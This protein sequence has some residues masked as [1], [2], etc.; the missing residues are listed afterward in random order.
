MTSLPG[1][2]TLGGWQQSGQAHLADGK[3]EIGQ[4]AARTG[5]S[6]GQGGGISVGMHSAKILAALP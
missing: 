1:H 4:A 2:H 5:G 3:T 6:W